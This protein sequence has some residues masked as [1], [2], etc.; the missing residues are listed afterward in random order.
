MPLPVWLAKIN[1]RVFN[2]RE[3]RRG[4]RPVLTHVG[5]TSGAT[6]RTPLEAYR[7]GDSYMFILMYGSNSDWVR[8]I[9]AAGTANLRVDGREVELVSPRLVPKDVAWP[10]LPANAPPPDFLRVTEALQMD[11]RE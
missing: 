1:K 11:V 5:R 9:L 4:A 7:V 6:Y 10:Q 8:N 3:I 2:P